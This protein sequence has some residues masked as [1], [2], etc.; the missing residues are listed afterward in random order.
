MPTTHDGHRRTRALGFDLFALVL[1]GVA[2]FTATSLVSALPGYAPPVITGAV[3]LVVWLVLTY[4]HT[5][6]PNRR[7]R[8]AR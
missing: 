3:L 6:P 2:V 1:L 7:A 4:R 5:R 8:K